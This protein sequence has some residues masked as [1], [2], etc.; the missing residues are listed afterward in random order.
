MVAQ[1]TDQTNAVPPSLQRIWLRTPLKVMH[2]V[3]GRSKVECH[4]FFKDVLTLTPTVSRPL[5]P[6][7]I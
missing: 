7:F 6:F 1:G 2:L 4:P 5:I 3:I